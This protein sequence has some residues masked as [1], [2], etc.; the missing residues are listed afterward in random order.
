MSAYWRTDDELLIDHEIPDE[1]HITHHTWE[2]RN[3]KTGVSRDVAQLHN[4]IESPIRMGLDFGPKCEITP[5]RHAVRIWWYGRFTSMS[6]DEAALNQKVVWHALPGANLPTYDDADGQSP[7]EKPHPAQGKVKGSLSS[8]Q[9]IYS[10]DCAGCDEISYLRGDDT[11]SIETLPSF[12]PPYALST[13]DEAMFLGASPNGHIFEYVGPN[14]W[15]RPV[16]PSTMVEYVPGS[17]IPLR[18]NPISLPI[19]NPIVTSELDYRISPRLSPDGTKIVWLLY[20]T[21]FPADTPL[22]AFLRRIH[23]LPPLPDRAIWISDQLGRHLHLVSTWSAGD[24]ILSHLEWTPN[25]RSISF[26]QHHFL[27]PAKKTSDVML[28]KIMVGK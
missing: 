28:C 14:L 18:S 12:Q 6:L 10:Y 15:T 19:P 23:V 27:G 11:G 3:F 2:L 7:S 16:K 24:D 1:L 22:K 26:L 9:W 4:T 20:Y 17:R 13:S 25:S 21:Y 8:S 5:D